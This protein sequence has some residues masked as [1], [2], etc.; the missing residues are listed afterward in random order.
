MFHTF[1]YH[2]W[3]AEQFKKFGKT[4]A[5]YDGSIPTIRTI[6]PEFIK[7]V[8][9]KQFDNFHAT[10]DIPLS[11]DQTTLDMSKGE[12]WKALRKI[13][14]PTFTTGR[15]KSMVEPMTGLADRTIDFLAKQVEKNPGKINVKPILQGFTLD[16]IAKVGFGIEISSYKG[17]DSEFMKN[18]QAVFE[19]I[20]I[21]SFGMA[22]FWNIFE[23]LPIMTKWL[24]IWPPEAFKLRDITHNAIEARIK[25]NVD[26]GDFIDRLKSHKANLELGV[27]RA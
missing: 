20:K 10:L 2:K 27:G 23:H 1:N 25:N 14:S 3:E 13:M 24:P 26:Y 21:G 15:L 22:M 18:A 7:E 11:D 16:T 19:G 9:V 8:T 12:T 6:D 5:K 4:W 17:E